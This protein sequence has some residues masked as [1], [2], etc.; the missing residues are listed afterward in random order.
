MTNPRLYVDARPAVGERTGIGTYTLKLLQEWQIAPP[1]A[2]I[3]CLIASDSVI[4]GL[5]LPVKSVGGSGILWYLRAAWLARDAYYFSSDSLIVPLLLGRRATVTVHDITGLTHPQTQTRSVVLRHRLLFRLLVNR[6]GRIIVPSFAVK[7]DVESRYPKAIGKVIAIHEA[8]RFSNRDVTSPDSSTEATGRP[9]VLYVGTVEPRKNVISL[10]H[11]FLGSSRANW[12]LVVVGKLGW[13][14]D[15]DRA[16]FDR[17]I[18]GNDCCR[19][20]GF[21]PDDELRS[22]YAKASIFAYISES[23]G[24]GLP[25]LEAME[26]GLPTL[27]SDAPAL[28]EVAGEAAKVVK[29]GQDFERRVAIAL[30]DL[31]NDESLRADLTARSIAQAAGFS[32]ARAAAE[33]VAYATVSAATAQ[34]STGNIL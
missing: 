11:A 10:I 28:V 31:I 12:D 3:V 23:E 20:L 22:L 34:G 32:W 1:P 9:Y 27:I 17:L 18:V 13:L 25:V 16:E 29:R 19:Y 4:H 26:L 21:V 6:V 24:F 7:S 5:R 33:T 2:D 8:A 14:S 30:S 15:H